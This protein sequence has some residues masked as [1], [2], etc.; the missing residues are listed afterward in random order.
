[1]LGPEERGTSRKLGG[2]GGAGPSKDVAETSV[3]PE[4]RDGGIIPGGH[5]VRGSKVLRF[6]PLS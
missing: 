1:M 6:S 3:L 4:A 5:K 2:V